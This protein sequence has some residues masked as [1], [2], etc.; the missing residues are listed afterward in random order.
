MRSLY[1]KF[2]ACIL[3]SLVIVPLLTAST[4]YLIVA[5][6]S[7]R[8]LLCHINR[9]PAILHDFGERVIMKAEHSVLAALGQSG[10]E[11]EVLGSL[12]GNYYLLTP[13]KGRR[14]DDRSFHSLISRDDSVELL[15]KHYPDIHKR[16][17]NYIV[18]SSPE[19]VAAYENFFITPLLTPMAEPDDF[20]RSLDYDKSVVDSAQLLEMVRSISSEK[21]KGDIVHLQDYGTRY[22][23]HP[24]RREISYWLKNRFLEIGFTEVRIDSFYIEQYNWG[25]FPPSWQYNVI[26]AISGSVYP[27]NYIVI[28]G[29]YDSIIFDRYG[30]P[31][32]IAPGADDNA[33]GVAALLEIARVFQ[34]NDY[35]PKKSIKFIP[36][37]AEEIGLF[38]SKDIAEKYFLSEMNIEIMINNDMIANKQEESDWKLKVFPYSH[39]FYLTEI[40]AGLFTDFTDIE[41]VIAS[42]NN[43]ASDSY[44]FHRFGYP[45]LFY[46]EYDFSDVYHS[47]DDTIEH[48]DVEY[49]AEITRGAALTMLYIDRIP[50]AV[51]AQRIVDKGSGKDVYVSWN[52]SAPD[53]I[54]K[55]RLKVSYLDD[56]AERYKLTEKTTGSMEAHIGNLTE[57][58][59]YFFSVSAVNYNG[60]AGV[61]IETEHTP[62][63]IPQTPEGFTISPFSDRVELSWQKNPELDIAGYNIYRSEKEIIEDEPYISLHPDSYY[64]DYN[65]IE[66]HYYYYAVTAVDNNK[67]ES[68]PTKILRTGLFSLDK[69]ILIANATPLTDIECS[70]LFPSEENL[71]RFYD[72]NLAPYQTSYLHIDEDHEL[73]I[74]DIGFYSTVILF[75][76]SISET[77]RNYSQ[78]I[79]DYLDAGG[80]L[81]LSG[82]NPLLFFE[83]GS[84]SNTKRVDFLSNYLKIEESLHH[85]GSY[86]SFAQAENTMFADIHADSRKVPTGNRIIN[87]VGFRPV[88]KENIIYSYGSSSSSERPSGS[89]KGAAVGIMTEQTAVLSFPLFYMQES[90]LRL[91]FQAI[92]TEQFS[93][94]PLDR[95]ALGTDKH[96]LIDTVY[97]NPF[98]KL[99][100]ISYY[101]EESGMTEI[102]VYNTK[103]QKVRTLHKSASPSG[104]NKIL[105]DGK[106]D[107]N[108][109]LG[110]GVYIVEL[111]KGNRTDSK[112]VILLK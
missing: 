108:R 91:F 35:R 19:A 12:P 109:K 92:L 93:E 69:G 39:H 60:F 4:D 79:Q 103:G 2:F 53:D 96:I 15:F 9:R 84:D 42:V 20:S 1:L 37:A 83:A 62:T 23:L 57:D 36:F 38:G 49:A 70:F 65:L 111:K 43:P 22:F 26:A 71:F 47:P 34:E 106:N 10:I 13:R 85:I 17:A 56:N 74:S 87:V 82:F 100:T 45:A 44:S 5:E 7:Y 77:K 98:N 11:Y 25:D 51:S 75:N 67:N 14:F 78:V 89:M 3:L 61:A 24:N 104:G 18:R 68:K 73:T 32:E 94:K 90:D 105:W 86:F 46:H 40:A 16:T 21:I 110:T 55:Y 95:E 28:G 76:D 29:H 50:D 59:T 31:M 30:D 97:P 6:S 101:L 27:D 80:N 66:N 58:K 52:H 81:I 64:S 63:S 41:P 107:Q 99:T 112:K 72:I 54:K 88:K 48:C 102:N 33:S 8:E